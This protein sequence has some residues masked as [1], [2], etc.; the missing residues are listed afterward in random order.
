MQLLMELKENGKIEDV[1][2]DLKATDVGGKGTI[3][4]IFVHLANIIRSSTGLHEKTSFQESPFNISV[5]EKEFTITDAAAQAFVFF[6]AGYETSSLTMTLALYEL[7]KNESIQ[8]KVKEEINKV[9]K[10]DDG[11]ISY[12][13]IGKMNYLDCVIQG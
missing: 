12:E 1:D 8:K 9:P 7:A 10:A 6:A 5:E 4:Y 13:E 2:K 3:P 11:T